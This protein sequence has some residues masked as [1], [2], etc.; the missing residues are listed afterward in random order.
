MNALND[1]DTTIYINTIILLLLIIAREHTGYHRQIQNAYS[2]TAQSKT[3][4][5]LKTQ[6]CSHQKWIGASHRHQQSSGGHR[7]GRL[8]TF[9]PEAAVII[10]I[11]VVLVFVIN[12]Y[13]CSTIK[14]NVVT[15]VVASVLCVDSRASNCDLW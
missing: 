7:E 2:E 5:S 13:Y 4:L 11:R 15:A 3:R 8:I 1:E 10:Y 6:R 9:M 12:S 14:N